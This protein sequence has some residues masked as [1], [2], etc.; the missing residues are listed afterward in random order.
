MSQSPDD[1]LMAEWT[2]TRDT[3]Q[4]FD[5]KLYD[6]RKYGFS[7]IT[8]LLA[9]EGL[10]LPYIPATLSVNPIVTATANGTAL[11]NGNQDGTEGTSGDNSSTKSSSGL[12]DGVKIA[13]LGVTSLL[14]VAV[15]WLDGQY[16]A[17]QHAAAS[18]AK[19]IERLLGLGLT[20]QLSYRYQ[21]SKLWRARQLLYGALHGAVVGLFAAVVPLTDPMLRIA[22]ALFVAAIAFEGYCYYRWISPNR[23]EG[24]SR[25]DWAIDRVQAQRGDQVRIIMTNLCP[26]KKEQEE[27]FKKQGCGEN[28]VR[29][30]R[31]DQPIWQIIPPNGKPLLPERYSG[32][33]RRDTSV[34]W[35]WRVPY[36]AELGVYRLMVD[37]DLGENGSRE[38][39]TKILVLERTSGQQTIEKSTQ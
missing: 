16:Q 27:F 20:D 9:I 22:L 12:P 18:R 32:E 3:I 29:K 24:S 38:L 4:I 31:G 14:I 36:D 2:K 1:R 37:L 19:V 8:V 39:P 28:G 7:F 25:S 21:F 23:L 11:E 17:Y 6:L 5:D 34:V 33:V 13:V 35:T 15:K 26:D 30:F 10:L